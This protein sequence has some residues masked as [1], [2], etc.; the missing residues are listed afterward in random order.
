M[1]A[2]VA[3]LVTVLFSFEA[4]AIAGGLTT[5]GTVTLPSGDHTFYFIDGVLRAIQ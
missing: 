3:N 1:V 5:N 2:R 4:N